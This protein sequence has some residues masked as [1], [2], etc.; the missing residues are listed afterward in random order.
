MKGKRGG[1]D[2][3]NWGFGICVRGVL[4]VVLLWREVVVMELSRYGFNRLDIMYFEGLSFLGSCFGCG[5]VLRRFCL[6]TWIQ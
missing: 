2:G 4:S 6:G 1:S 3:M 5:L